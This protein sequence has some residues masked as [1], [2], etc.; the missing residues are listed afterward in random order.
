MAFLVA[1]PAASARSQARKAGALKRSRF[2]PLVGAQL[3]M[4]GGGVDARVV[5]AEVSDLS[6][7]LRPHDPDRFSLL[8]RVPRGHHV[9]PGIRTFHHPHLG[10]VALFVSPVDRG[11]KARH[12]E[13]VVNRSRS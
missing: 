9:S 7:V 10:R 2:T 12:F 4:T 13:A 8:F 1:A 11:I 5:L 6:P 3:R